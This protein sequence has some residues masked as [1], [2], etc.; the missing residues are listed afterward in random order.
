MIAS[1]DSDEP[2]TYNKTLTSSTKDLWMKAIEEEMEFM[3]VNQI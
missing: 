1:Q 2:N 3:K